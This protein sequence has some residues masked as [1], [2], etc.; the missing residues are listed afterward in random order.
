MENLLSLWDLIPSYCGLHT[1]ETDF[2]YFSCLHFTSGCLSG[3]KS[4]CIHTWKEITDRFCLHNRKSRDS[5]FITLHIFSPAKTNGHYLYHLSLQ[6]S[7]F[8]YSSLFNY[9]LIR[10]IIK[11]TWSDC[12]L[13]FSAKKN[14]WCLITANSNAKWS[15]VVH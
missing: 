6:P 8:S 9:D 5:L 3:L 14:H 11:N 7:V 12:V 4:L 1:Q 13:S 15:D 2:H 10:K